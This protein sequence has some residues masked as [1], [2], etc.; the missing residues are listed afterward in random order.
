[1]KAWLKQNIAGLGVGAL[2][3]ALA[4][5]IPLYNELQDEQERFKKLHLLTSAYVI[6]LKIRTRPGDMPIMFGGDPPRRLD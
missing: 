4:A 6:A 5:G 3:G 2:V 1:M